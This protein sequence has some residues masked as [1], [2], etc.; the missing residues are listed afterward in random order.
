MIRAAGE[1]TP[2]F[3]AEIYDLFVEPDAMGLGVGRRLWDKLEAVARGM[4]VAA[5]GIDA[6]PNAVGFYEHMGAR[7]IGEVPSGSI[8]GRML[9]RM[10]KPLDPSG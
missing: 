8:E 7:V 6:D 5:I 3:T 10:T 1:R 9:P 2:V 4:A